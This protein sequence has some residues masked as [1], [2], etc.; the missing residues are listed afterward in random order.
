MPANM[1]SFDK[2]KR[3]DFNL[4]VQNLRSKGFATPY[5]DAGMLRAGGGFLADVDF[6]EKEETLNVRIRQV[7]KGETYGSIFNMLEDTI[8]STNR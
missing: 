8:K 6:Q 5:S 4:L 3:T 7:S 2:V 1:K